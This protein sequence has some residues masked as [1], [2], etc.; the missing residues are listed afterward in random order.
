MTAN[1]LEYAA[2]NCRQRAHEAVQEAMKVLNAG[3]LGGGAEPPWPL[4]GLRNTQPAGANAKATA[5]KATPKQR[6][7]PYVSQTVPAVT[8]RVAH[9]SAT[10]VSPLSRT[11]DAS[12]PF[13]AAF[14]S[15]VF[16][17]PGAGVAVIEQAQGQHRC[18]AVAIVNAM[19]TS[20]IT[21]A[22]LTFL[23][24]SGAGPVTEKDATIADLL[25]VDWWIQTAEFAKTNK[26]H[27]LW[28]PSREG[29]VLTFGDWDDVDAVPAI[30]VARALTVQTS[31]TCYQSW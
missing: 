20:K 7:A 25:Q 22:E 23:P 15:N 21:S 12:N 6:A 14:A 31:A 19:K 3:M 16:G 4:Q 11:D 1:D 28:V 10:T 5:A 8:Q 29:T 2:T 13:S 27:A 30:S 26:L 17:T 18:W 9:S 24:I